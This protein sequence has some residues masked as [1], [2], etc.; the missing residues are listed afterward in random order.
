MALFATLAHCSRWYRVYRVS[1]ARA[2]QRVNVEGGGE[3]S[4]KVD[5]RESGKGGR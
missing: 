1:T 2:T 4:G 3:G 5:V